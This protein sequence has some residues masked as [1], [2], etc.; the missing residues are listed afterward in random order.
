MDPKT[1]QDLNSKI[2]SQDISPQFVYS[3]SKW[4]S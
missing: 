3:N 4:N 1:N 2:D